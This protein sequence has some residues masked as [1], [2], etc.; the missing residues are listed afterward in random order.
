LQNPAVPA[1]RYLWGW[2]E[3]DDIF[4]GSVRHRTEFCFQIIFER[5]PPTNEGWLRY[6]PYSRFNAADEDCM[7][8]IDS[9]T[10]QGGG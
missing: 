5:L 10:G 2:I 4:P 7:R 6:E 1:E 9:A 3:Y 8:P